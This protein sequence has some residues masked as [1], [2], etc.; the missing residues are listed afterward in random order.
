[1]KSFITIFISTVLM[2]M[3]IDIPLA[4]SSADNRWVNRRDIKAIRTIYRE[5]ET[6]IDH[7]EI[8]KT[9]AT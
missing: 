4:A 9:Q 1:M 5:I 6:S 2:A 8:K 3:P 7:G